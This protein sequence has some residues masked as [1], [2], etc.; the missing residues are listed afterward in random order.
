MLSKLAQRCFK[1]RPWMVCWG[2]F[3][4]R[5]LLGSSMTIPGAGGGGF[6]S[7]P[8]FVPAMGEGA[9]AVFITADR[10]A[11]GLSA[12]GTCGRGRMICWTMC[13]APAV[14]LTGHKVSL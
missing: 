6:V 5:V 8:R 3:P 2:W 13:L 14:N 1:P 11:A 4:W 10:R 7:P 12:C 9:G